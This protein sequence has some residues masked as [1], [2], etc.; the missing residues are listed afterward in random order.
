MKRLLQIEWQKLVAYRPFWLLFIFY[1]A[2][3]PTVMLFVDAFD[4]PFFGKDKPMEMIYGFPFGWNLATYLSS[5]FHI[6]LG[7]I[8]VIFATNEFK[9]RTIRQHIIDGMTRKE[10]FLA[11]LTITGF[12]SVFATLYTVLIAVFGSLIYTGGL[13]N[14]SS[15]FEYVPIFLFQTFG[16][17]SI[18][19]LISFVIKNSGYAIL[20]YISVIFVEW[21]LRNIL[22]FYM[23]E[24]V[25]VF[26]PIGMISKLTPIPFIEEFLKDSG[27]SKYILNLNERLIYG[28]LYIITYL[29][30]TYKLITKR[31]F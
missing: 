7:I 24:W 12:I 25:A 14:F 4:I 11:K 3:A 23:S 18:A 10:L 20:L 19:M 13:E 2:L 22:G 28:S 31:D 21:L 30:L 17:M 29:F 27:S 5:W 9:S 16:Y 15:G 1:L 6:L 8:I 26:A